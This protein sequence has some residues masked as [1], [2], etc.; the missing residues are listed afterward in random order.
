MTLY[1]HMYQNVHVNLLK[2]KRQYTGMTL[3]ISACNSKN[4]VS[5][6]LCLVSF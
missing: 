5:F 2:K 3:N 1:P 6:S 4:I